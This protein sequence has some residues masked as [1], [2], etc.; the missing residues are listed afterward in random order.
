MYNKSSQMNKRQQKIFKMLEKN[1]EVKIADLSE[2]FGV[3]EMTIRRDLEKM[4]KMGLLKR[5][6]G[7][8]ILVVKE[9]TIR[10]RNSI[11]YEEKVRIGK[12]AAELIRDGESIFID[13]G[14]T[15]LQIARHLSPSK[16]ITVVTNALNVAAE[17]LDKGVTTLLTGGILMNSTASMVGPIAYATLSTMAFDR[18]FL[19]A[20]GVSD[21]HGYSNSNNYETEI[22]KLVISCAN[23]VN[24][25]VDHSKF[26]VKSLFSFADLSQAD[27]IITDAMPAESLQFACSESNVLIEIA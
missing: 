25:V 15:T 7:G 21:V 26:G 10:L 20:S 3:T 16:Q 9:D 24:I 12:K 6:F 27:R 19:G 17:L 18:A 23:E 2:H 14:S 22:K 8:A 5:T 13:G 11:H 1:F 4:E